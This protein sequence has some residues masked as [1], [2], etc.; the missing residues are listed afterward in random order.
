MPWHKPMAFSHI[1]QGC[2]MIVRTTARHAASVCACVVLM[3]SAAGCQRQPTGTGAGTDKE[4]KLNVGDQVKGEITSGSRVN[5][6]DGSRS[7]LYAF[8]LTENQ[9]VAIEATGAFCGR[10]TLFSQ[11]SGEKRGTIDLVRSRVEC[12]GDDSRRSNVVTLL[13]PARAR[14][15]LAVSGQNPSDYGPFTLSLKPVT[16]HQGDVLEPGADIHDMMAGERKT[17][18]LRIKQSGRCQLDMRSSEFDA[19]LALEGNGISQKNDD[20]GEGTNARIATFLEPGTYRLKADSVEESRG[21]RAAGLYRIQV[22]CNEVAIPT[23]TRLQDGGDLQ[24]DAAPITGLLRNESAQYRFT[25]PTRA[26]VTVD[27][28]SGDFD[29]KLELTGPGIGLWDDDGGDS[30]DAR[31][32]TVLEPGTYTVTATKYK[33]DESGGLFTLGIATAP[34]P[35]PDRQRLYSGESRQA[36]LVPGGKDRYGLSVAAAGRYV[37]DMTSRNLDSYLYLLRDGAVVE[38]DDDGG[39]S[40]NARLG[41]DLEPGDYEIVA[42]GLGGG[43]GPYRIA[44]RAE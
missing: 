40:S 9:A 21:D 1:D 32:V 5:F 29:A 37:I 28:K 25:L 27:M 22:A 19:V 31:I 8:E 4:I 30:S 20:G 23:G 17:Y 41:V 43:H 3:L 42:T 12:D 35:S 24:L 6:S 13:S 7:A 38:E 16:I 36:S 10:L 15:T 39:D 34:P 18:Q 11:A 26:L 44:V 33:S 2:S 14:Y